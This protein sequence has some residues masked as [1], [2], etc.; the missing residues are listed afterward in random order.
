MNVRVFGREWCGHGLST[1]TLRST[2]A[3]ASR[4]AIIGRQRI[5]DSRRSR[6]GS[7]TRETKQPK[8]FVL[9]DDE[10]CQRYYN[11]F[12]VANQIRSVA[13]TRGNS[14]ANLA[15]RVKCSLLNST[16]LFIHGCCGVLVA[17]VSA[18]AFFSLF[19]SLHTTQPS[20]SFYK[21]KTFVEAMKVTTHQHITAAI[22]LAFLNQH[23][24]PIIAQPTAPV[25]P[26][27][28]VNPPCAIWYAH[29]IV[30]VRCGAGDWTVMDAWTRNSCGPVRGCLIYLSSHGRHLLFCFLLSFLSTPQTTTYDQS[31]DQ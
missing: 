24:L 8:N 26:P 25:A 27:V 5:H 16:T 9:F 13:I 10:E 14:F 22:I 28:V 17:N 12:I 30:L 21:S 20:H 1:S 31:I 15:R 7:T 29:T 19:S 6:R 2:T 11:Y 3:R 23:V 18:A 4:S